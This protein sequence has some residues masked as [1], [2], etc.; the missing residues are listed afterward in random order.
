MPGRF[1]EIVQAIMV[2][3]INTGILPLCVPRY[4][5]SDEGSQLLQRPEY[6][7]C[8]LRALF[9]PSYFDPTAD[10]HLPPSMSAYRR[11]SCS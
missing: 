11:V 2:F 10:N 4:I 5:V 6:A 7:L 8:C 3:F 9:I 1:D